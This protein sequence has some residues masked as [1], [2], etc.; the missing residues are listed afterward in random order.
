MVVY[1]LVVIHA[2]LNAP[3]STSAPSALLGLNVAGALLGGAM[4]QDDACKED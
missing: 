4:G 1:S 2:L 3:S